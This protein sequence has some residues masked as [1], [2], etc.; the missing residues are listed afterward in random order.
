MLSIIIPALNEAKN[1]PKLLESIKRQTYKDYEIIVVDAGSQDKTIEIARKH[2]CKI[3]KGSLHPGASRNKGAKKAKGDI[4]LFLDADCTIE[5][6]FLENAIKDIKNRKLSA[7][8]SYLFPSTNNII[9]K[10]FICIFNF[11]IFATQLFYPNACGSGIFCKKWLHDRIKGFDETI[12]LSEDMDYAKRVGKF[13]KFRI[14][15]YSKI[16][17]SMRRY[18]KEGRLKV[19]VKLLSSAIYRILFGEIRSDIFRYKM[20]Y[21]K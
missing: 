15:K 11:W 8:G 13:G 1:L 7:A 6:N 20:D 3:A 18:E 21:K 5:E 14:V 2:W 17:Y 4:L 16:I 19:G 12:K 9:D 10:L